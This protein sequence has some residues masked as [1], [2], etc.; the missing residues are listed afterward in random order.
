MLQTRSRPSIRRH[1]VGLPAR[2]TEEQL[3]RRLVVEV[4]RSLLTFALVAGVALALGLWT[5]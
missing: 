1:A 4:R 3:M 5:R 2:E